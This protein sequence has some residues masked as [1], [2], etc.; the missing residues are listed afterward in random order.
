MDKAILW[1]IDPETQQYSEM[2]L[3]PLFAATKGAKVTVD[4]KPTGEKQTIDGFA[5]ER[6][7]VTATD[8]RKRVVVDRW[9]V[10][11]DG[12]G[13]S[14]IAGFY[15][16]FGELALRRALR[17]L[18]QEVWAGYGAALDAIG[19][20][21]AAVPGVAVRSTLTIEDPLRD[22]GSAKPD[23][24]KAN[25]ARFT[26]TTD[27][28]SINNDTPPPGSFDIPPGFKLTKADAAKP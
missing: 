4:V 10:G 25:G 16:S 11:E 6:V 8:A 12:P 20:K 22:T 24:S 15:R 1:R 19:Q 17:D 9:L 28:L 27:V 21:L 23:S 2:P 13:L 26:M 14:E 5:C 18:P 3:A 7:I